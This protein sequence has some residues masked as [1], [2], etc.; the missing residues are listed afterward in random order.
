M[1]TMY[2]PINGWYKLYVPCLR[3]G[4][5]GTKPDGRGVKLVWSPP[6]MDFSPCS[7]PRIRLNYFC[8]FGSV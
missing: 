1:I 3:Q 5:V 2:I 6:A 8:T 4:K 7:F